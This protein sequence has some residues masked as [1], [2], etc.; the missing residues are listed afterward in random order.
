MI[1]K[2]E[3]LQHVDHIMCAVLVFLAQMVKD[4][5]FHQCLMMETFLVSYYLDSDMLIGLVVQRAYNLSETT[6]TN[7]LQYLVSV[8]DVIVQNL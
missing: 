2:I 3:I 5:H 1:S 4:T 6:L 8:A 7:Y